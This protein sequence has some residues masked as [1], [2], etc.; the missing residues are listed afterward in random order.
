MQVIDGPKA[1]HAAQA[2]MMR[3]LDADPERAIEFAD[4]LSA[5]PGN[6]LNLKQIL[7]AALTDGG[8]ALHRRDLVERGAALWHELPDDTGGT[9]RYNLANAE[10]A[11][12]DLAVREHDMAAAW[13][14]E[15]QH[16]HAAREAFDIVASQ[17]EAPAEMRAQ[18]LTNA[19]N[20]Y[21]NIGRDLDALVYYRRAIAR[22]ICHSHR[23]PG[24]SG[25]S[26]A[27]G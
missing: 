9:V 26:P 15:R 14:G 21:D 16:L 22:Q 17:D 3:L 20:A 6:E 5:S 10:L 18:A 2:E 24:V 4:S 12:W 8:A 1:F 27:R 19:G 13:Q 25:R 23:R 7:A 11:M